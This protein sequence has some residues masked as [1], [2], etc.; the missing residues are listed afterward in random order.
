MQY[1]PERKKAGLKI[2]E[3]RGKRTASQQL[4]LSIMPDRTIL[5]EW[6]N[7]PK[8]ILQKSIDKQKDIE[9]GFLHGGL[10]YLGFC[11]PDKTFSASLNYF[12]GF[13]RLFIEKLSRIS[14]LETLRHEAVINLSEN[15]LDRLIES[16]PLITGAEYI[17]IEMLEVLWAGL[18][19]SFREQIQ[20]HDGTV[21]TFF[22][23]RNP[24]IHLAGRVFFHLV[25]NKNNPAQPFAFM[26][27][28]SAGMGGDG[29]PR[30]LPLKHAIEAYDE[31]DLLKLLS[32][33]Y[34]AA[35]KSK[36][37]DNLWRPKA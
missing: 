36:L 15:E 30:H 18:G 31:D 13:A 29:T 24:A 19:I 32:T 21:A 6:E 20:A 17:T 7:T 23:E 10:F 8:K 3:H 5:P 28:Y 22:H 25:E 16:V 33:V 2:G 14:D 35:K 37:I 34:R 9:Q 1:S 27:T 11:E 26:A 4:T 12:I